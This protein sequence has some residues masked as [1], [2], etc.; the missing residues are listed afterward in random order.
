MAKLMFVRQVASIEKTAKLETNGKTVLLVG[1]LLLALL[2]VAI[3][4]YA[5]NQPDAGRLVIDLALGFFGWATGRVSGE[6][7]GAAAQQ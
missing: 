7:A 3:F 2:G 4:L 5:K 6:H 1:I